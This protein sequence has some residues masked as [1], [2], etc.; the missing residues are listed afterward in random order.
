ME[1][2]KECLLRLPTVLERTGS[3]R[4]TWWRWVK[5]GHAPSPVKVGPR[6]TAWRE[7]DIDA[8]IASLP[9]STEPTEA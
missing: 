7:S 4:S 5:D 9:K 1:I 2:K 3:C 8:F 6:T